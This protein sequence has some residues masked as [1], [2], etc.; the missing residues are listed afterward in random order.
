MDAVTASLIK[1]KLFS[2][3]TDSDAEAVTPL[4]G[5]QQKKHPKGATLAFTDMPVDFVGIVLSGKLTTYKEDID[6][7]LN[8]IR[9]TGAYEMFGVDIASTPKQVQPPHGSYAPRTLTC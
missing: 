2:G 9:K 4:L 5:C 3:L 1:T 6:G 8:L 7:R